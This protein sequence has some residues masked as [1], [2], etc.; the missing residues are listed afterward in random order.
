MSNDDGMITDRLKAALEDYL[1]LMQGVRSVE[2]INISDRISPKYLHPDD[3]ADLLEDVESQFGISGR[4]GRGMIGVPPDDLSF[5]DL[6]AI[7]KS[8][9]W[10]EE[11]L[12]PASGLRALSYKVHR[13]FRRLL[14]LHRL[15]T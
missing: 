7:I 14:G 10:P 2:E 4:K 6:D 9:R 1:P 11:W 8:G 15:D 5:R 13:A 12:V 3:F